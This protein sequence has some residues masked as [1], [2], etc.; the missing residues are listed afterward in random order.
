MVD[1]FCLICMTYLYNILP[2][3]SLFCTKSCQLRVGFSEAYHKSFVIL[4][5]TLLILILAI[6]YNLNF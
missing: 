6:S 4:I 5:V 1:S 3:G 2:I